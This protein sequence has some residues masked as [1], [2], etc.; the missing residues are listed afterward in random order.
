MDVDVSQIIIKLDISIYC[1][2][3]LNLFYPHFTHFPLCFHRANSLYI[4]QN[5]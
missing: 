2:F 5:A 3:I 4:T 1:N